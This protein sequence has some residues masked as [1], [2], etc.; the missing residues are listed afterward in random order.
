MAYEVKPW[1]KPDCDVT[2]K[3]DMLSDR[4]TYSREINEKYGEGGGLNAN[5][6]T[7]EAVAIIASILGRGGMR[8]GWDFVFKT[9]DNDTVSLD[10]DVVSRIK[11]LRLLRDAGL[12]EAIVT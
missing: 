3:I 2:L 9:S 5:Y 10:F 6:R 12:R 7:V 8:Y 1:K 11:A 4:E